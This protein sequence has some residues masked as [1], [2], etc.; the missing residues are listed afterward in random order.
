MIYLNGGKTIRKNPATDGRSDVIGIGSTARVYLVDG[1]A[2][3]IYNSSQN[4]EFM[5]REKIAYL[6]SIPTKRIILPKDDILDWRRKLCGYVSNYIENLGLTSFVEQ[7]KQ[8]IIDEL[9]FLRDDFLLMGDYNVSV[10]DAICD[11]TVFNRGAYLVDCGRFKTGKESGYDRESTIEYNKEAFD[12]YLV[13]ELMEACVDSFGEKVAFDRLSD[14]YFFYAEEGVSMLDYLEYDMGK[15]NL[16]QYV[17]R[18]IR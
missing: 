11:N 3:K 5:T 7:E 4:M 15:E 13:F 10:Y 18:K 1:D 6:K 17:N 9:K 16:F 14:E 8:V 12:Q 2:Y